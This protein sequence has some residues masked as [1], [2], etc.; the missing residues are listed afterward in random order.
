MGLPWPLYFNGSGTE[1]NYAALVSSSRYWDKPPLSLGHAL[2]CK[3][4]DSSFSILTIINHDAHLDVCQVYI[5]FET[6]Q[7]TQ[8]VNYLSFHM[9]AY[10]N[11][12]SVIPKC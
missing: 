11:T 4:K 12:L 8:P 3:E 5:P 7:N 9:E 10:S 1:S 2:F 6:V